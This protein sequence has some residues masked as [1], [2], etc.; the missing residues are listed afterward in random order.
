MEGTW[1]HQEGTETTFSCPIRVNI[2]S[3]KFSAQLPPNRAPTIASKHLPDG[4]SNLPRLQRV[5]TDIAGNQ[6]SAFGKRL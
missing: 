3:S 1:L 4:I 5:E 6:R 2:H